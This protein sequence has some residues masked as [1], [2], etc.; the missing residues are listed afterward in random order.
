MD[1]QTFTTPFGRRPVT[2]GQMAAQLRVKRAVDDAGKPGSNAPAAVNKW[3]V[4]R[5]LTQIRER[6]GVSDRS[7]SVLN[8]LLSFHQE[9]ALSLPVPRSSGAG[10]GA[11]VGAGWQHETPETC[12]EPDD[13]DA[14]HAPSCDLIV[15]PS[16]NALG[17]RAH[18]MA[19]T[20]LWRH[21]TALVSA[22]LIFRRDSPNG[23]RYARKDASGAARFSDAFGFDLTPL[24]AR[25]PEFDAMAEELRALQKQRRILKERI[26]LHRRDV[27]KLI[28]CGLDEGLGGDWE[29]FRKRFLAL[30]TPLRRIKAD[31]DLEA[32]GMELASLRSDV[33]K[34][35]EFQINDQNMQ[36]NDHQSSEHQS[37][38]NTQ[39][40]TDFEP[41]S[42]EEGGESEPFGLDTKA[43]ASVSDDRDIALQSYPF[44]MVMQACPDLRD[45]AAG[46]GVKSWSDFLAAVRVV[47]PMI[48]ISPDAWAAARA[49]LGETAAHIVVATI[50]QRSVHSSEAQ[51]VAGPGPGSTMVLVNGSPA[52][53]SAGGYLRA[54]TE[55]ARAGAFTLGPVLM[56]LIGQRGKA[57]MA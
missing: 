33:T 1:T 13:G 52:I 31:R 3:H 15:F 53:Q 46:P 49:V 32:L 18:G 20:T 10:Q 50:L 28:A 7:L 5:T 37:N 57:K 30:M 42:N 27:G 12:D 26:S 25:A 23:K 9:T 44:G 40:H 29:L 11:G 21:L 19:P 48:G 17:Q 34:A 38:S 8:A 24:V 43:L 22:G 47:R 36:G 41:S 6:L 14:E 16:N 39:T 4:F 55:Q 56:A 35:L 54:L 45:Y 2:L 51:T